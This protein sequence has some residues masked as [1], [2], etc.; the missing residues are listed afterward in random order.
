M[1]GKLFS[2]S[3]IDGMPSISSPLTTGDNIE[4]LSQ[5]INELPLTLI[6]PLT[7]QHAGDLTQPVDSTRHIPSRPRNSHRIGRFNRRT[8][9]R[10]L[11]EC[12]RNTARA[13]KIHLA[14][15]RMS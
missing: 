13:P 4:M 3:I 5:N 11:P 10:E 8:L 1:K 15:L 12:S 2:L 6:T 14:K 7:T 9:H